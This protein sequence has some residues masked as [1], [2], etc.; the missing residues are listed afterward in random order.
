MT[1]EV[2]VYMFI[3]GW[4]VSKESPCLVVYTLLF[5]IEVKVVSQVAEKQSK[6]HDVQMEESG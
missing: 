4:G 3:V 2:D 6:L 5:E 1:L